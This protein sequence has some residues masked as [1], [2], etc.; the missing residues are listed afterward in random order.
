MPE[1]NGASRSARVPFWRSDWAARATGWTSARASSSGTG[2]GAAVDP[3]VRT[4]L[5]TGTRSGRTAVIVQARIAARSASRSRTSFWSGRRGSGWAS[6][7]GM[8]TSGGPGARGNGGARGNPGEFGR[9]QGDGPWSAGNAGLQPGSS[10]AVL[11]EKNGEE[12]GWS[13]AFP[14]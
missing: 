9:R 13:P 3:L 7:V 12:P 10:L 11:A 5:G 6:S 8:E 1:G 2:G 14:G 4:V